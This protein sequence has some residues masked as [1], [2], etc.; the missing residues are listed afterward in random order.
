LPTK[1]DTFVF[2]YHQ[3]LNNFQADPF[4][5]Q[6]FEPALSTEQLLDRY[7][8]HTED[9]HS[10]STAWKNLKTAKQ[11]IV[12]ISLIA[13]IATTILALVGGENA[14]EPALISIGIVVVG[15]IA[16]GVCDRLLVKLERGERIPARNRK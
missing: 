4:P 15:A 14:L 7:H 2:E 10:C 5:G 3:W 8:S 9:C 6:T 13:W 1:A 12:V 11:A 16:W